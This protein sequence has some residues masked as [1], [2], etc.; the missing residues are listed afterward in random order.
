MT[1]VVLADRV[2][3]PP[4]T[5]RPPRPCGVG[6]AVW[7]AVVVV[8]IAALQQL[9][10]AGR[11][12][13][14]DA[15][16]F[17]GHLD[18]VLG[19]ALLRVGIFGA[20]F[21]VWAT[22]TARRLSWKSLLV[23]STLAAALFAVLLTSARGWDRLID[24]NRAREQYLAALP[25][26]GSLSR[27]LAGFSS[28]L[29]RYPVHVKGHPPGP[30]LVAWALRGL[31][32]GGPGWLAAVFIAGGALA[33]PFTLIAARDVAGE[34]RA[35]RAAPFLVAAPAAVWMATSGDALFAG[36][37]AG[38]VAL[39]IVAT[40]RRDRTGDALAL[41]GGV[42]LGFGAFL[43]Y[44][45]VLIAI[46]PGVVAWRRQNW[47]PVVIGILGALFVLAGFGA[48]G[49]WWFDGLLATHHQYVT[50]I[51]SH[52]PY[53]PFLVGN[54]AAL[55]I[56]VG[57]AVAV[58]IARLRDRRLWVLVG[59]ALVVV[60]AADLSGMSKGEVERIWLPFT[61]WLLLACAA[62]GDR[63][64]RELRP[65]RSSWHLGVQGW[66]GVQVL[67]AVAVEALVRTP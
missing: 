64:P 62:L 9:N 48:W 21:V 11:A 47:R 7:V 26:V 33:V 42:T 50:G 31:G 61:P 55:A 57:P 15:P 34:T 25:Q 28:H 35:R 8:G 63:T 53:W 29:S 58:G 44:G 66:L 30:V 56:A 65:G 17:H 46:I 13:S 2:A 6:L 1:R 12:I 40:G 22:T 39:L 3:D 51:A 10:D 18:P 43:S 5:L 27:F 67:V 24:P 59:C 16:P 45:L 54:L 14:I 20:V 37:T 19:W 23:T 38:G 32:L 49:F 36:V 52:R 60:A 4:A 41:L